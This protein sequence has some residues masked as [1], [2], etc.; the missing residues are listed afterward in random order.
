MKANHDERFFLIPATGSS[1]VAGTAKRL[2]ATLNSA[3][4]TRHPRS[5]AV[6][7]GPRPSTELF[8]LLLRG[9][10]ISRYATAEIQTCIS[11][12]T[13][14]GGRFVLLCDPKAMEHLCPFPTDSW[15]G[16]VNPGRIETELNT[17][18]PWVRDEMLW[19]S[20]MDLKIVLGAFDGCSDEVK[21]PGEASHARH[22]ELELLTARQRQ[23]AEL[24]SQGV[25]NEVI[26]EALS[27]S[28]ATVKTHVSKVL[29]TLGFESRTELAAHFRPGTRHFYSTSD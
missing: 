23:V 7:L 22:M 17:A 11:E 24:V 10:G 19:C 2:R 26:S 14:T 16:R 29:S 1:D 20:R 8:F 27:I 13:A 12:I 18:M 9:I 4:Y 21:E 5:I 15:V 3:V 6:C 25:R 28:I